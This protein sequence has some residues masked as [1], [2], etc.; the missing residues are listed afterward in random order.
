MTD[1]RIS[2]FIRRLRFHGGLN[3]E[4]AEAVQA[5]PWRVAERPKLS[6]VVREGDRPNEVSV[7]LAGFAQRQKHTSEGT[8]QIMAFSL[9]GDP[10]D[11]ECLFLDEADFSVQMAVTGMI[12][13]VRT[14]AIKSLLHDRRELGQAIERTLLADASVAREWVVNVGRRDARRRVAHLLCELLVRAKAQHIETSV[15]ELP[16][17]QEQLADATGL[18]PIHINRILRQLTTDGAIRRSGRMITVPDWERLREIADF[19][20]RFLHMKRAS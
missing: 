2:S 6:Y 11:F 13:C 1:R 16:F 10:L 18:T 15:F 14:E 20:E 8:R 7:L 4:N 5:L 17:T 9:P 12:A 3:H 19:D